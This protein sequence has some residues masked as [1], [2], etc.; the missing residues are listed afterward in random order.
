[1]SGRALAKR[2]AATPAGAGAAT[3]ESAPVSEAGAVNSVTIVTGKRK[4]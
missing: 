4:D 1:V 2:N 3:P